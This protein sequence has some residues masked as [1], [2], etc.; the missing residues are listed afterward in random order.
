MQPE[1]PAPEKCFRELFCEQQNCLPEAYEI[2]LFWACLR[3]HTVPLA[4]LL[5]AF[6]RRRF[7]SDLELLRR[8]GNTTT[9]RALKNELEDYRHTHPPRGLLRK[10]LR[11]RVSGRMLLK[12][13]ASLF[14]Q[15]AARE[16]HPPR[17]HGGPAEF[18]G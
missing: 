17:R 4:K 15:E 1:T 5:W 11:V 16:G 12:L 10:H 9:T 3:P 2:R 7:R 14:N 18:P 8:V 13:G 6:N